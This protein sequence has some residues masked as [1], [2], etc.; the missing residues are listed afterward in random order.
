MSLFK[1][2]HQDEHIYIFLP[3]SSPV[4]NPAVSITAAIPSQVVPIGS[5]VTLTCDITLDPSVDS[6]VMVTTTWTGP[7]G[8]VYNGTAPNK[9]GS[10]YQSILTLVSLKTTDV[11]TYN[12]SVPVTPANSQYI[13]S[14]TGS[15]VIQGTD[16]KVDHTQLLLWHKT[17]VV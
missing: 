2:S 17:Y 6:A 13:I 14:T 16:I 1:V 8:R 4:P 12:C 5:N 10:S 11:G 15:E 9:N 3:I 7:G